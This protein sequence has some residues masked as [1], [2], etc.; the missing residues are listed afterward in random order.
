[1]KHSWWLAISAR[2]VI[3]AGRTVGTYIRVHQ[4]KGLAAYHK[5]IRV[6]IVVFNAAQA[7]VY[8]EFVVV[9]VLEEIKAEE[10][11]LLSFVEPVFQI[12]PEQHPI[13]GDSV[14]E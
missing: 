8:A 14:V 6:W 1:M 9:N 4:F 10:E 3:R 5:I 11:Y 12:V 7:L 13:V 2:L